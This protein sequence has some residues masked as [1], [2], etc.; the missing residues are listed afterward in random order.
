MKIDFSINTEFGIFNDALIL[1]DDITYSD[2]DI[3]IMKQNRL[4]NWLAIVNPLLQDN[5]NGN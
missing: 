3:E 2:N 4:N 1:D 5:V